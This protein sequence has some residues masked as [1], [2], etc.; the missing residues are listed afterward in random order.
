MN[1]VLNV[2]LNGQ[3]IFRTA[4]DDIVRADYAETLYKLFIEKFPPEKGYS[5]DVMQWEEIGRTVTFN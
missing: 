3:H 4:K 2:S 5:V 1:Y